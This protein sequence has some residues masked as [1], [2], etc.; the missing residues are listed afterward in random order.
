M[1]TYDIDI[2]DVV[3]EVRECDEA[4]VNYLIFNKSL[5]QREYHKVYRPDL[6]K[7][8]VD[9]MLRVGVLKRDANGSVRL[10]TPVDLSAIE[11]LPINS[12]RI[13]FRSPMIV[14]TYKV[15]KDYSPRTLSEIMSILQNIYNRKFEYYPVNVWVN[16]LKKMG[17]VTKKDRSH[18]KYV[19]LYDI[20]TPEY[21]ELLVEWKEKLGYLS[22]RGQIMR[23]HR[24]KRRSKKRERKDGERDKDE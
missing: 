9:V 8:R 23:E 12:D 13:K 17:I 19:V 1:G 4:I 24:E 5:S 6:V 18:G 2:E 22:N 21:D 7:V 10:R 16:R 15:I 20:L 3:K 11:K 14:A